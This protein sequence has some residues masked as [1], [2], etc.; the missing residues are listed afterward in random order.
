VGAAKRLV[1]GLRFYLPLLPLL[2]FAAAESAPRLWGS[3]CTA[4]STRRRARLE[5]F[6][7]VVLTTWIACVIA[8]SGLMQWAQH[9]WTARQAEMRHAIHALLG[10]NDVVVTNLFATSKF[11]PWYDARFYPVNRGKLDAAS[12]AQ[13]ARRWGGFTIVFLDR[14]ES[15]FWRNDA[16]LNAEFIASLHP[17]PALQ[18]D[19]QFDPTYRL[20][21][22]RMRGR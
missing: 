22:W 11:M 19:R 18:V 8:A 5:T 20:R 6:A 1:L 10:P 17:P 7:A 16:R 21:V 4:I 3:L 2:A 14:S 13:M 15:E 9:H 12:A